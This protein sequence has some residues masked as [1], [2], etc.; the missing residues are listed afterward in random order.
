[1]PGQGDEPGI[2]GLSVLV[3]GSWSKDK[4]YFVSYFSSLFNGG[5]K[6]RWPTRAYVDLFA[7]PGRCKD[8]ETGIEFAGSPLAAL[9]CQ[10]PFTHLFFNDIDKGFVDALTKRQERLH[11]QANVEYLNLDC[12]RAAQQIAQQ[13]PKGALTL[14]F[15]DPWNYELTFDSLA[16]LGRRQATDLIVTFHTTAIKRNAHQQI[17]AVDAFLDDQNWRARYWESQGNVSRPPTT[18]LIDTFQ[19]R[20][21]SRLGYTQ[22]GDPMSIRNSAGAPIFYLLF[23]SKHPKGLEFW[24]KSSTRLRSGQRSMF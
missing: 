19:S 9:E 14:A 24:E 1:M 22:F 15:I 3:Q 2:D 11:P 10:T 7:G 16:H 4:L 17:A 12:N 20:L 23:A 8:R 21:R 13:I 6:N 5:M 18:V